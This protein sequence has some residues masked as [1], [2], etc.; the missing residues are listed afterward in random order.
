MPDALTKLLFPNKQCQ[1]TVGAFDPVQCILFHNVFLLQSF[2]VHNL[3]Y[4]Y[5]PDRL[6]Y[7]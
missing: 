4:M 7:L 1:S 3:E 6:R 2:C 5:L